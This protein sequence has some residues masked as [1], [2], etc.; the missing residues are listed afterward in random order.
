[1]AVL[2]PAPRNHQLQFYEAQAYL[3]RAVSKYLADGAAASERLLV[4]ATIDHHRLFLDELT[5]QAVRLTT[6]S[7]RAS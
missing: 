7:P 5:R 6:S 4:I 2:V 1:M 3:A